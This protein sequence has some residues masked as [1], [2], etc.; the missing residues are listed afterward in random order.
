MG[1]CEQAQP[2]HPP[3]PERVVSRARDVPYLVLS[4]RD[5]MHT[6]THSQLAWGMG[7]AKGMGGMGHFQGVALPSMCLPGHEVPELLPTLFGMDRVLTRYRARQGGNDPS[8]IDFIYLRSCPTI[9]HGSFHSLQ[10][11]CPVQSADL[12]PLTAPPP[13][14]IALLCIG[15]FEPTFRPKEFGLPLGRHPHPALTQ[16]PKQPGPRRPRRTPRRP[17]CRPPTTPAAMSSAPTQV[18]LF[19]NQTF[20]PFIVY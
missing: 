17:S 7:R 3:I 19:E 4:G 20:T 16:Q 14:S 5:R 10:S 12:E 8:A 15:S 1:N 6:H 2:T 9:I 13:R 11:C 18:C